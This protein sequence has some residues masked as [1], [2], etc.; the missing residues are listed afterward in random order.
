MPIINIH[1]NTPILKISSLSTI[2]F[3]LPLLKNLSFSFVEENSIPTILNAIKH[4]IYIIFCGIV[5]TNAN[6]RPYPSN[7][8][9]KKLNV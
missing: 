3:T 6:H 7:V 1:A 8:E 2:V 9:I 4:G 5:A